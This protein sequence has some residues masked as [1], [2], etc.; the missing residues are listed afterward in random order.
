MIITM[1]FA[2]SLPQ[3]E[4]QPGMP[5]P[6]LENKNVVVGTP[7]SDV[8]ESVAVNRFFAILLIIIMAGLSLF[9]L[10]KLVRGADWRNIGFALRLIVSISV[11]VI[12]I[13]YLI[14]MLPKS[15]APLEAEL[16]LP[17]PAPIVTAPLGPVPP[18]LIWVVGLCLLVTGILIGV[19]IFRSTSDQETMV[20]ILG[21][22]AE[23]ARQDLKIGVGLKDVIIKCYKQMS[24]ALEKEQ[25]IQR[26][27]FMTT[28]EFEQLLNTAGIPHDPT[29]QLTRLFEAARYGDWQP[30]P[31]DEQKAITCLEAIIAYSREMKNRD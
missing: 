4:L 17:T 20:D 16:P 6:R 30:N 3:L 9:V 22:E 25:G 21:F 2:A 24:F 12:G 18:I 14:L 28:G 11:V 29:H 10:Y 27:N 8:V 23:K 5:I 19:W 1:T 31:I 13:L 7:G 15:T 26:K